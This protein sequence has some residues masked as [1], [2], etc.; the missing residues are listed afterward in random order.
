M[1]DKSIR[2][3][4]FDKIRNMLADECLAGMS[5]ELAENLVPTNNPLEVAAYQEE[6]AEAADYMDR[7]GAAPLHGFNDVR[8]TLHKARIGLILS[9]DELMKAGNTLKTSRFV[10]EV[11]RREK[12]PA[13]PHLVA[14]AEALV[15]LREIEE[16]YERSIESEDR[17]ADAASSQL[18]S[19][20]RKIGLCHVKIRQKLEGI[21]RSPRYKDALMESIV[22]QRGGRYVVP[23]RQEHRGKVPGL[24]HDQ[25]GSGATLF[26]EP[27]EI[28][29]INNE[30]RELELQEAEE[31]QRILIE[32]TDMLRPHCEQIGYALDA[33]ARLD[34]AFA[35]A[36][37]ASRMRARRAEINAE[38][39][40]RIVRGRHPLIPADNVVPV[41]LE[42]GRHF[43]ALLITG[44]NTGGKTVTLKTV[45]LF[46]LMAQAGLFLPADDGCTLP[47]F[48]GVFADIGDE[49][50]IEQSLST[51]SSHM[52]NIV[53]I[54]DG[55]DEGSLVLLD[56]LGAGTDPNEGSALAIAILERLRKTNCRTMATTHYSELKA[57]AIATAGVENAS[58]EFD[59][60]TLSPTFKLTMGLPGKSNAFEISRR[61]GLPESVIQSAK[62]RLSEEIVRFEDVIRSAE[63]QKEAAQ[64]EYE[65]AEN[66][67]REITELHR[68]ADREREKLEQQRNKIIADAKDEARKVVEKARAEAEAAVKEIR[69]LKSNRGANAEKEI[70][71]ARDRLRA[72]GEE[73]IESAQMERL[74]PPPKGLIPGEEVVFLDSRQPATVL[75][76]PDDKGD[77]TVQAGIIKLSTNVNKLQR[78]GAAEGRKKDKSDRTSKLRLGNVPRELDIRGQ[79]AE[80][81]MMEVDRYLDEALLAGLAEVNIIHG[82]GTGK[83]RSAIQE[84]LR[85][86]PHVK[87]YRSGRFGE[88]EEGVTVVTLNQ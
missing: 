23:V 51:F 68:T 2:T 18:A 59:V 67:R 60:E 5:R 52:R 63:K 73:V 76:V 53:S 22:T 13:G 39:F 4:E 55:A 58:M 21:V 31:V 3:L 81:G 30:L 19:I 42:L 85:R 43:T 24:V 44:P 9:P 32:L 29:E 88:G 17:V 61:L 41:S 80:D 77:L 6:T 48:G 79:N 34:F 35:K 83:L 56:E 26:I 74:T 20:R 36:R 8:E 25:S 45:G 7:T 11:F 65:E 1:N 16:T 62:G 12:A 50:S 27:L 72:A 40:V 71:Q 28:V 84:H 64:R 87:S 37:L 70:Q 10:K 75:T 57:Y 14:L 66:L 38:G 46:A 78:A 15:S 86:H 49:Q 33:L 82:K 47:V 54:L 69:Q